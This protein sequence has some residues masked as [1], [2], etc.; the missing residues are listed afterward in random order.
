[1]PSFKAKHTVEEI[2]GVRCTIVETDVT[3]ERLQFLTKLLQ[4]NN[5]E[6]ISEKI[7]ETYKIGVTD[8]LFNPV[9]DVYK[10]RLKTLDGRIVSHQHW[11][12]LPE[13]QQLYINI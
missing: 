13:T 6:V 1:M 7:G 9:I 8:L 11:F 5:Y 3:E 10:R 12:Q 2:N 4:K